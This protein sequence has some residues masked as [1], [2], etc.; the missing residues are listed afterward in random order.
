MRH[1]RNDLGFLTSRFGTRRSMVQIHSPRP[2]LLCQSSTYSNSRRFEFVQLRLKRLERRSRRR[3]DR[4]DETL[5]ALVSV[6]AVV[7]QAQLYS[8]RWNSAIVARCRRRW[9]LHR[10]GLQILFR[11]LAEKNSPHCAQCTPG[12]HRAFRPDRAVIVLSSFA[13]Y[14]SGSQN[15]GTNTRLRWTITPGNDLFIVWNRVG[16]AS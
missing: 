5:S 13:H 15:V 6:V 3:P 2:L 1:H 10:C 4:D 8:R 7:S 9:C 12:F 14:D 11:I 16:S